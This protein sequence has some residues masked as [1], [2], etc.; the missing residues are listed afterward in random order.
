MID[1]AQQAALYYARKRRRSRQAQPPKNTLGPVITGDF[2]V[3]E[4]LTVD[5]GEW[6]GDPDLTYQWL[7]GADVNHLSPIDGETDNTYT[8]TED[9]VDNIV[10]CAVIATNDVAVVSHKAVGAVVEEAP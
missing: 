3:D 1:G 8:L 5:D 9:D 4:E 7:R 6:S 10:T 2:I